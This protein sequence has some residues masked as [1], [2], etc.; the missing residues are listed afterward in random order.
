VAGL[1]LHLRQEDRLALERW[2][3]ADPVALRLHADDL[4]VRV[5]RDLAD[6]ALAVVVGHPVARLDLL[7]GRDHGVEP[8][9][10]VV[11]STQGR[12][13]RPE[14]VRLGLRDLVQQ[15]LTHPLSVTGHV[16]WRQVVSQIYPPP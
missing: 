7:I 6:Q 8:G 9:L 13:G 11:M 15:S 10:C 3:P 1:V 4:R 5:L 2:R 12:L 14:H 16:V